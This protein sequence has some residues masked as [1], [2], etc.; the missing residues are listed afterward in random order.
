MSRNGGPGSSPARRRGNEDP[1]GAGFLLARLLWFRVMS[2]PASQGSLRKQTTRTKIVA[3]LGPASTS[4]SMIQRLFVA[5]VDV[6]RLNMAH[7]TLDEHARTIGAIRR[8]MQKESRPAAILVDL[9][10]PK[11]RIGAFREGNSFF[12][13]RGDRI[14]LVCRKDFVGGPGRVGCSYEGL[15]KDVRRGSRLLID[16][17]SLELRVLEVQGDTVR[18]VVKYGGLLRAHKGINLPG[19]EVKAP[20]LTPKDLRDL[21]FALEQNVDFCA[22]SFVRKPEDLREL[23]RRIRKRGK[24]TWVIAKIE[25]PEALKVLDEILEEADGI[26]V[27]RGDLGVE[28][29]PAAVPAVQKD[30]IRRAVKAGKPVITAT[31]M[32]ESMV[33]NPRPTRAEASDVANAI[34]DGTSAVM[35]SAET[36]AG[37]HPLR[38][39]RTMGRI[40]RATEREIFRRGVNPS[41]RRVPE[42]ELPMPVGEAVVASAARAAEFCGAR[43]LVVFT[44]SGRTARLLARERISERLFAFTP[45]P[46]TLRRLCLN[47]GVHPL[48][49]RKARSVGTL[50]RWAERKLLE[51][52]HVRPGDLVVYISGQVQVSGATNSLR[53]RRAGEDDLPRG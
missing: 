21:E 30:L 51:L 1:P 32:L 9:Q 11:I 20:S 44:E 50:V 35:L 34:Y 48:P 41:R 14:E 46:S 49:I 36:A 39:V 5:G 6:F 12:L 23:K 18:T 33:E 29:G 42:G 31:Q 13:E 53:I 27:A 2:K 24:D 52:H 28:I 37:A 26:M 17:G 15:P 8:I 40:L 25:R 7:G 16:D 43:A 19:T 45:H 22:L 47:W 10:G 38:A 3:T 4:R